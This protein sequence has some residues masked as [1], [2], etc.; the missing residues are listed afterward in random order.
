MLAGYVYMLTCYDDMLTGYVLTRYVSVLTGQ[1]LLCRGAAWVTPG[2][3]LQGWR[4]P[5][6]SLHKRSPVCL[7]QGRWGAGPQ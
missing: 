6:R 5:W 3:C 7:A 2:L 4:S 1:T